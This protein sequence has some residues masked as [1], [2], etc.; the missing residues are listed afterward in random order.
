MGSE[1]LPETYRIELIARDAATFLDGRTDIQI[2]VEPLV[3]CPEAGGV[4]VQD[5]LLI[6][7]LPENHIHEGI[8]SSVIED[9]SYSVV[10]IN[11]SSV[12]K[13]SHLL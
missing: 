4:H 9:C 13:Y 3:E 7:N 8:L 2:T 10:D 11:P 12:G 1:L 6:K 5:T